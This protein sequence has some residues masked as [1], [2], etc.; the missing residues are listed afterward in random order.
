MVLRGTGDTTGPEDPD[1]ADDPSNITGTFLMAIATVISPDLPFQYLVSAELNQPSGGSPPR[2]D[3][4][5]QSL[6]LNR[7]SLTEPREPAGDPIE[8]SA[9]LTQHGAFTIHLD[10]LT[11]I[12]SA[13]P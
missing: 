6:S 5:L 10:A 3:I 4:V 13:N 1:D 8:V 7:G 11:I 2:L 9:E 12:G